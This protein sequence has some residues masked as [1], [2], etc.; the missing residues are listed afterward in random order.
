MSLLLLPPAVTSNPFLTAT[1]SENSNLSAIGLSDYFS[2]PQDAGP[3]TY[4]I[5]SD[6]YGGASLTGAD[7]L[8]VAWI[9]LSSSNDTNY[10]VFI[11]ASNVAGLA[12]TAEAAIVDAGTPPPPPPP[13]PPP[14]DP[15][16]PA[17]ASPLGSVELVYPGEK[18]SYDLP[19]FFADPQGSTLSYWISNDPF[20]NAYLAYPLGGA[21]L[22]VVGECRGRSYG[23]AVTSSNVYGLASTQTLGVVERAP[24]ASF[25]SFTSVC[26]ALGLSSDSST[27]ACSNLVVASNMTVRGALY[28]NPSYAQFNAAAFQRES[29]AVCQTPGIAATALPMPARGGSTFMVQTRVSNLATLVGTLVVGCASNLCGYAPTVGDGSPYA[30][31]VSWDPVT[32]SLM[33]T[34]ST[35]GGIDGTACSIAIDFLP[36]M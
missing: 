3:L 14:A 2:D 9:D 21:E 1:V 33:Y 6:P 8:E 32:C 29:A 27:I 23:V 15:L 10:S 34:A 36:L 12:T 30:G 20:S 7:L 17:V 4:W 13:P 5:A 35:Y 25:R 19:R 28:Q 24:P 16:P 31:T 11:G 22:S 18:A 26:E